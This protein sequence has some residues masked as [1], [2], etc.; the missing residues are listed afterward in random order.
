MT[1]L[2]RINHRGNFFERTIDEVLNNGFFSSFDS[3]IGETENSYELEV[4]VPGMTRKDLQLHVHDSI[5]SIKG[6]KKKENNAFW[7]RRATEFST[8]TLHRTFVLPKDANVEKIEAK[9]RD[10]LL[11]VK[12]PKAKNGDN[13]RLIHI[14]DARQVVHNRNE[15]ML[16]RLFSQFKKVKKRSIKMLK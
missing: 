11:V 14:E 4:A 10:G 8:T 13:Y 7:K 1:T 2:M 12:M 16:N 3:S 9:C 6:Q 15:N 5:L